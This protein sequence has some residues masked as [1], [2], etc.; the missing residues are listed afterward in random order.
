MH[1]AILPV[2]LRTPTTL[3]ALPFGHLMRLHFGLTSACL[4]G[5]ALLASSPAFAEEP[6]ATAVAKGGF[7]A[8]QFSPNG[9][10]L[11]VTGERM[12]G[13]AELT[14]A[15]GE[16]RWH[17]DEARVGVHSRYLAD[18]SIGFRAKRAGSMRE[19]KLSSTGSITENPE[20]KAKVFAHGDAIYLRTTSGVTRVGSGDRFFAPK[21]SPDAT[22]IV[23][24][25]LATGVHVY[26]IATNTQ[27]RIGSGTSPSWS[28]D[29]KRVAFERTE[30]DGHNIVGSDLW[31]W[32]EQHGAKALTNTDSRI[33]RHPAWSPSGTQ[34]AFDDDMGTIFVT[35]VDERR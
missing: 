6:V 18:G 11:L 12:H 9:T 15:T 21:L 13:L 8:P 28:P 26:D 30:D 35:T 7:V 23:F 16:V 14:I 2:R 20:P 1:T 33:E 5:A 27:T 32:S 31:I 3:V 4:L 24:S 10:H 22:K 19:L 25:G 17:L 29:S 34:I